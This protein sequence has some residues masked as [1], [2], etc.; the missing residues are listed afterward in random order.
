[1]KQYTGYKQAIFAILDIN[2]N[3][4]KNRTSSKHQSFKV[5]YGSLQSS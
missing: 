3:S 1:M 4:K 2:Q 5:S